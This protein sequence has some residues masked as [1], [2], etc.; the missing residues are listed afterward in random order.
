MI[1]IAVVLLFLSATTLAQDS[2]AYPELPRFRQVSER[3][4]R[5]AQPL[6][7]GVSK[8]HELGINT[9]I[10]L[11]GADERS[12]AEEAAVRA[13]GLNYFNVSLPRWGRP[14]DTRV[15]R[16]MELITSADNGRVFIHCKDGVDRTGVIV[17]IYRMT[18][19]GWS[20]EQAVAE[21][22]HL[23]MRRTQ[24]WMRDYVD[25]YGDRVRKVG[26][27]NALQSP[28]VDE[29]FDDRIGNS[30]RVVER[31]ALKARRAAARFLHK[32][33]TSLR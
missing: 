21:A 12:R 28:H 27:Q 19:D 18:H 33:S 26:P 2:T 6:D 32:F 29:E 22:K 25:D 24:F 4:Y 5:G 8:L 15:V 9:V 20:A 14:E 31:G 13:L 23:G 3:L 16:I 1:R 7:G 17:A 30:M 11:R 10:N